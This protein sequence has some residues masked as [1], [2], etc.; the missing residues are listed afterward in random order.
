MFDS[1]RF[2]DG[3]DEYRPVIM[4]FWNDE[5]DEAEVRRQIGEFAG[6][7]IYQFFIHPLN[8][9]ETE[10]LSDR[11]FDMIQVAI[12]C[13]REKGMRFWIYDEYNWPSG[14]VGGKLIR[15][16]PDYRMRVL[17]HRNRSY[18]QGQTGELAYKGR[19]LSAQAVYD[20][21]QVVDISAEGRVDPERGTF[22]WTNREANMCQ[23]Y[24]FSED[25]Q[26]GML[27]AG[28][29]SPHSWDQEGYLDV[30]NPE[31]VRAFLD[32]TH[33]RYAARFGSLFG[34]TV[35][36][37]FTDEVS[38]TNPFDCGP[39]TIP[40]TKGFERVFA[41]ANGYDL[42]PHLSELVAD[43]GIS[44]K[45]RYDY[46]RTLTGRF[47]Q[48]YAMQAAEW[49][50]ERGLILTGHYSGEERLVCDLLQAGNTFLNLQHYQMPAIDTI[51]ST[52]NVERDDFNLP[53]KMVTAVAEHTGAAR[54]LCET[55]SGSGWHTT[56]DQMKRVVNRLAVLG[57]NTIQFMG[58]YYSLR[59]VRKKFPASYPPSHSFQTPIFRHYGL[60]SDYISRLCYANSL[61]RHQAEI[62]VLMPTTTVWSEYAPRFDFWES[63]HSIENNKIGDLMHTEQTL[64]GVINALMQLQRDF[65]LLHEPSLLEGELRDGAI[66][67][68]G[69]A[70]KQLILP[71]LTT[72]SVE[73]WEK[74]KAFIASGGKVVLI[75]FIPSEL[76][77]RSIAVEAERVFGWNPNES[78]V[79]TRELLRAGS[80][81]VTKVRINGNITHLA[82]NELPK[83]ANGGFREALRAD[84]A[85]LEQ[86]F[87]LEGAG[88]EP[89]FLLHRKGEGVDLFLLVNDGEDEYTGSVRLA[90]SGGVSLYDPASGARRGLAVR[91]LAA[92]GQQVDLRLAEGQ[93]AILVVDAGEA[94][95]VASGAAKEDGAAHA[96]TGRTIDL[97]G[98]WT[99]RTERLNT[100]RLPVEVAVPGPE[101][102]WL[103]APEMSFPSNKGF[104]LGSD[105]LARAVF[106][107]EELPELLELVLDPEIDP[108]IKVNGVALRPS[109]TDMLWDCTNAVYD[110]RE[111]VR[112]G[113]NQ[114]IIHGSVP[115]WGA[116]HGPVFPV[117][118]GAF[119]VSGERTLV[120]LPEAALVPGSWA[121]QGFPDYSGTGIYACEVKL[122]EKEA[123]ASVVLTAKA[124]TDAIEVWLNGEIAGTSLW[125]PHELD[126][127]GRLRAG[128]NLLELKVTNTLANLMEKQAASGLTG[129]VKLWVSHHLSE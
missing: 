20:A 26:G 44:R 47:E 76:P 125:R 110:I 122:D 42:I 53:G 62:A 78:F 50:A 79:L 9:L 65:D 56:L 2:L 61:G 109:R 4:W 15:D 121:E 66:L 6:Q 99:F 64:H 102:E 58:A 33:E 117:L 106:T 31:A 48:A 28:Q 68:R 17:R 80:E 120:K 119:G 24:V 59:N 118:R 97:S 114:I 98:E 86:P 43:L 95:L 30:M 82:T 40:W 60:F 37:V 3:A 71:S 85:W 10:Y 91:T 13:A 103:P 90:L 94:A 49:C 113:R 96:E 5:I 72:L 38:L 129:A 88:S 19:F 104:T 84:L 11:F 22:T 74:L 54:T 108:T 105:Y 81:R 63:F 34:S 51:F 1:K 12:E 126:L 124:C 123:S 7:R 70:Y 111:A 39:D 8:G 18:T 32:M 116:P 128:S 89:I 75:N 41:E 107:V 92:G 46:W 67:F 69:H 87:E 55:F 93:A 25:V 77:D 127:T 45:V 21:A 36:G 112:V 27:A 115:A 52:I 16:M 73:V 83:S 14:M 29:M 35:A 23:V 100:L 101:P 57:V